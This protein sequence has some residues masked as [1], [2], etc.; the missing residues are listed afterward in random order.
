MIH[1]SFLGFFMFR[2]IANTAQVVW[3][4]IKFAATIIAGWL[5]VVALVWVFQQPVVTELKQSS[6]FVWDILARLETAVKIAGGLFLTT[7]VLGF[8][9]QF[10]FRGSLKKRLGFVSRGPFSLISWVSSHFVHSDKTHL[11]N[12]T[13]TLLLFATIAILIVPSFGL[14]LPLF[15]WML[16]V[17][18]AGV[19]IFGGKHRNHI[20]AS[21]LVMGFYSFDVLHGIL[22][23]GWETAVALLLLYFYGKIIYINLRHTPPTTSG[24][25]HLWGFI[26]GIVAAY[27]I[28]PFGPLFPL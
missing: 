2:R 5:V 22:A 14:I 8:L 13:K 15:F 24:A 18:G 25:G 9:D 27:L 12:N 26:S 17:Q 23:L 19:W 3:F 10:I 7:W 20:G 6:L 21:G 1:N 16:I 4:A 11:M 28:S